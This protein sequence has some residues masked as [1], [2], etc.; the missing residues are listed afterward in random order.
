LFNLINNPQV[1]VRVF[2]RWTAE[3]RTLNAQDAQEVIGDLMAGRDRIED[4]CEGMDIV[5][6]QHDQQ[7]EVWVGRI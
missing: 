3:V 4:F 1:S 6:A 7:S 5:E 2:D